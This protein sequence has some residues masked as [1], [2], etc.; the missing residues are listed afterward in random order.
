M[1]WYMANHDDKV[2]VIV[3]TTSLVQQMMS[4][5]GDYSSNDDEFSSEHDC[6]AIFSGQAKMN[7]SEN[8]F[9]STW[10]SIYKLPPTWF[11]QFGIIFGDEVHGFKS[12]SLSN[13]MNKS[14]NT[15]YRLSGLSSCPFILKASPMVNDIYRNLNAFPITDSNLSQ[16]ITPL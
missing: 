3:P 10:Q 11:G 7:I 1:R 14:K 5:F 12:K 15:A 9:I 8:V 4:D 16:A 2:L 13:I 6:H